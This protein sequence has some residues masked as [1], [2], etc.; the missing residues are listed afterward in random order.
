MAPDHRELA[1]ALRSAVLEAAPGLTETVRMGVP[2]YVGRGHVLYIAEYKDHVNLGFYRGAR[3]TDR[4]GI[5]EGTGKELRHVKIRDVEQA[6]AS[7][8][9]ALIREA[10][11]LDAR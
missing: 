1:A 2:T 10:V 5:L 4:R 11:A 8:L 3:I 9:K 7:G 6:R